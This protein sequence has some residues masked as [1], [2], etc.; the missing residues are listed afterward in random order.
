[1]RCENKSKY[2]LIILIP[3]IIG[4]IINRVNFILQI[5]ST[6]PWIFVIAFIIFWF[7][8]GKVFAKANHNRV[9]SFLIGSSL[10]A[11]SFLFYLWQFVLVNDANKNFIIAGISENYMILIVP[12]AT[13]IMMMFT[14]IIDGTIISIVSYILMFIIFS[15]GFIYESLK[16]DSSLQDES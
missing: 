5:Y 15:I 13:K 8:V 9:K 6:V 1:M 11:I 14:D 4:I 12:I 7:W 16:E 3:L 10:W 2:I